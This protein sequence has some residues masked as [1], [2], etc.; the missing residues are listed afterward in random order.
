MV[1]KSFSFS[2]CESEV[3]GSSKM[4]IRAAFIRAFA[5]STICRAPMGTASISGVRLGGDLVLGQVLG[6]GLLDLP[7]IGSGRPAR[8]GNWSRNMFS[9]TVRLE[10]RF[11]S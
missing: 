7:R 6:G 5:I 1:R 11:S 10:N 2:R 9:A 8:W 4:M 3:V